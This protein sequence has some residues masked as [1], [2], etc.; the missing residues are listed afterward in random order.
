MSEFE[1][2]NPDNEQK[3]TAETELI[4]P[5]KNLSNSLEALNKEIPQKPFSEKVSEKLTFID[6]F[7]EENEDIAKLIA[8][9]LGMGAGVALGDPSF[10]GFAAGAGVGS[11]LYSAEE[12][13]RRVLKQRSQEF[14]A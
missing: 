3:K 4:Q 9:S 13:F 6:K 11:A 10:E 5:D 1:G 12:I 7:I 2:F 8:Y 14:N